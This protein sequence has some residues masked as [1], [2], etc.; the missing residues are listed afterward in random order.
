MAIVPFDDWESDIGGVFTKRCQ[1]CHQG[2]PLD[3]F[4]RNR[5]HADGLMKSCKA[6]Q[7]RKACTACHLVQPLDAFY[8][9]RRC[10]D[11]H[12][13]RCKTCMNQQQQAF[14]AA[15]PE[16]VRQRDARFRHAY[17]D[18]IPAR[19]ARWRR[20]HPGKSQAYEATRRARKRRA[21]KIEPID[22]DYVY[23]RDKGICSLCG[24][25]VRKRDI[26]IDHIV[27]LALGGAHCL[28]NVALVHLRCNT[29]KRTRAVPQQLHLIG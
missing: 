17:A 20:A 13:S 9:H 11:G 23:K 28:A 7:S 6:C 3:Q 19:R 22:R 29:R 16:H 27:P 14:R 2:K 10:P 8:Q 18:Q 12:Q 26:S 15:H 25:K 5:R 1:T 24:R 4:Y 21:G